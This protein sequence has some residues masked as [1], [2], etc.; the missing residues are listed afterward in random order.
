MCVCLSLWFEDE[1]LRQELRDRKWRLMLKLILVFT[2]M[3]M[4]STCGSTHKVVSDPKTLKYSKVFALI[5]FIDSI[6]DI[7]QLQLKI[8]SLPLTDLRFL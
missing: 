3:E 1:D 6:F 4:S 8:H 2:W 7:L 5:Y